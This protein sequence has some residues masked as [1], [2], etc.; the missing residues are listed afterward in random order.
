MLILLPGCGP[1]ED[2]TWL[3]GRNRSDPGRFASDQRHGYGCPAIS[4]PRRSAARSGSRINPPSSSSTT[5]LTARPQRMPTPT[6]SLNE[7]VR[8]RVSDG[9]DAGTEII[10]RR[11]DLAPMPA[12]D[13]KLATSVPV[14]FLILL[15]SAFALWFLETFGL[16]VKEVWDNRRDQLALCSHLSLATR[17]PAHKPRSRNADRTDLECDRW[18]AWVAAM[19]VRRKS[20]PIIQSGSAQRARRD[21]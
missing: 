6:S 5:P 3:A 16:L 18:N 8:V 13:Q 14:F 12:P 1:D 20:A 4:E 21:Y 11:S 19:N 17:Q 10:V 9:D 2:E 7:P 15:A